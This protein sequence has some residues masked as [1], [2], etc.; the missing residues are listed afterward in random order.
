VQMVLDCDFNH[1]EVYPVTPNWGCNGGWTTTAYLDFAKDK[2]AL[3]S[4]KDYPYTGKDGDCKANPGKTLSWTNVVGHT[5]FGT[6]EVKIAAAI[7]Q[8]GPLAASID[9][10]AMKNYKSGVQD[11]WF[12][13][14]NGANLNHAV[15]LLGFGNDKKDYWRI[16]NSFGTEWGE[17]GY[18]RLIR[19]RQACGINQLVVT[20]KLAATDDMI[21]V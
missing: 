6:D 1:S 17:E 10:L 14:C 15:V 9:A 2:T 3:V 19:G 8:Y 11:P 21:I 12:F 18:Y 7:V 16:Q 4:A 20:A 13:Q 5:S